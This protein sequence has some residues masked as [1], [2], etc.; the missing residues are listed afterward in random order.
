MLPKEL[1]T[2]VFA[3]L[4]VEQQESIIDSINDT[5]LK[6][7]IEDLYVDDA[8]DMLEDL[9]ACVVKRVFKSA[10]SDTR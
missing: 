5:E 9:S 10:T 4:E 3:C 2:E 7:I 1:A 8:V 6:Y